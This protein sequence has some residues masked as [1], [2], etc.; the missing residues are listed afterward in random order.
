MTQQAQVLAAGGRLSTW[1]CFWFGLGTNGTA[2]MVG[3]TGILLL[4]YMT[5]MLGIDP[6][7]AGLL[8]F[9]SKIYDLV[10]DPVMGHIS[11]RTRTA[12]GRRR[13]F[14]LL[15]APLSAL[16]IH[17]MFAGG[18]SDSNT[19]TLAYMIFILL[20]Y[21]TGYTVFAVPYLSMPAEMT[22]DYHERTRIMSFRT[23]FSSV[24]LLIGTAI[25]P[26]LIA[27][28]A[29][30]T[31]AVTGDGQAP[32][33]ILY[34]PAGAADCVLGA[35]QAAGPINSVEGFA[36]MGAVLAA[37]VFVSMV[38]CFLG[39]ARAPFTS[40]RGESMGFLPQVRVTLK[41]RPFVLLVGT[42]TLQLTG[43]TFFSLSLTFLAQYVLQVT[44]TQLGI[45]FG[46][47]SLGT[48]LSLPFWVRLARRLGKKETY[49]AA[50]AVFVAGDLGL[51][52]G[53]PDAINLV[54]ALG[55]LIGI[56][57]GGL[58]LLGVSMLPDVME[59]DLLVTGQRREGV[60]AG[61]WSTI[62][63]GSA[64]VA[65]LIAGVLLSAAG[66]IETTANEVACQPRAAIEVIRWS[67]A[68]VPAALMA[69]SLFFL[70]RYDLTRD[71]LAELAAAR[72]SG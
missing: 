60:Y 6:S 45:F 3:V 26:I 14:L 54:F 38:V 18:V 42:K 65:S 30:G 35:E 32:A 2:T 49:Y 24:G 41:N 48:M 37:I 21:A 16:A 47:F 22:T 4:F 68:V 19:A 55:F 61:V 46:M 7:V 13:P 1:T 62:E 70:T 51:L 8:L 72:T 29:D 5:T 59:Y 23:L 15:G 71:K 56:A 69:V 28:G 9:L 58:I 31:R 63:K 17:L 33:E 10:T 25:A 66:F 40:E 50:I 11:D 39:T 57:A 53:H 27:V 67:A 52:A 20:L 44:P 64:A 34:P 36:F 43:V 12:I